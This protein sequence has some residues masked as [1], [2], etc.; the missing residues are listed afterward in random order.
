M[1][2]LRKNRHA[3]YI[4]KIVKFSKIFTFSLIAHHRVVQFENCFSKSCSSLYP[5]SFSKSTFC[6]VNIK[7][8]SRNSFCQGDSTKMH[9]KSHLIFFNVLIITFDFIQL[10]GISTLQTKGM[11]LLFRYLLKNLGFDLRFEFQSPEGGF[12]AHIFFH[13]SQG[14]FRK[15]QCFCS[16]M[17]KFEF[18]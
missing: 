14:F 18:L 17:A 1:K 3:H 12:T 6:R 8:R 9:K 7:I 11:S 2:N 16:L 4:K 13:F 15:N 5:L 10:R